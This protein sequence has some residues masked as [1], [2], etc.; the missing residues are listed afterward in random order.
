MNKSQQP[1]QPKQTRW[2]LGIAGI[3]VV[4]TA[5]AW[6]LSDSRVELSEQDYDV[7][8]ALYRVCNQQSLVGLE[9]IEA[10]LTANG[11]DP[12]EQSESAKSI[13]RIIDQAKAG[14]WKE[15]KI[16]CRQLLEDQVQH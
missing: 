7:T 4:L 11:R 16:A 10:V 5:A 6:F 9:K 2:F 1:N 8:I 12:S 15:A 13:H 14:D 3:A